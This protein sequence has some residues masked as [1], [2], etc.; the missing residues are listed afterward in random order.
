MVKGL[1]EYSFEKFLGPL[2]NLI[3]FQ[4]VVMG[5]VLKNF[6]TGFNVLKTIIF[7]QIYFTGIEA[8]KV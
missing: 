5:S 3:S 4:L 6:P 8:L 1:L 2:Y 7:R